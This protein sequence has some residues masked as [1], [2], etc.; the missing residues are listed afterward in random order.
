MR[1]T[2]HSER[3]SML[4]SF[5]VNGLVPHCEFGDVIGETGEE[6]RLCLDCWVWLECMRGRGVSVYPFV[7]SGAVC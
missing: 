3:T 5:L 6:V 1:S 4:G 7:L 2:G